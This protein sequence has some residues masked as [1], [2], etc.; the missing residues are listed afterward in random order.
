MNTPTPKL[1]PKCKTPMLA[2]SAGDGKTKYTCRTDGACEVVDQQ[3]RKYLADGGE[4][5]NRRPL[6]G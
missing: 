5:N 1:C 2:E 3:G 4:P 6:C